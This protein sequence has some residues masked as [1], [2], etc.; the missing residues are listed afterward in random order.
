MK[1]TNDKATRLAKVMVNAF[2]SAA[3]N[4]AT[5]SVTV[6]TLAR[7]YGTTRAVAQEALWI[8]RDSYVLREEDGRYVRA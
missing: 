5:F 8:L 6:P 1:T 3:W 4:L 7:C 2:N